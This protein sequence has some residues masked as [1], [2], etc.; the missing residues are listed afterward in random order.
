VVGL[1]GYATAQNLRLGVLHS[2]LSRDGPGLLLRDIRRGADDARAAAALIAAVQPDIL[3]LLR[4]DHDHELR[5]L[6]AFAAL[7][8]EA[9]HSFADRFSAL[10]NSG[11][12][13][14]IDL[15]GDGRIGTPDDAQGFG[16]FSGARGMALLSRYP[17]DRDGVRDFSTFAWRD[18]PDA[19][20]PEADGA[21]IPAP[22][23][24]ALQ[25]L[26]S[27]G[28]W[29]VPILLPEGQRL[30]LLAWHAGT[31]AFG[32]IPGRNARR[33]H[34]ENLFWVHFLDG[35]L[36]FAPPDAPFVLIGNSNLD[37]DAGGGDRGAI[38]RLL[39]HPAV[40]D[41]RPTGRRGTGPEGSATS[42]WDGGVGA[43]R[44][45]Y[46]LPAHGITVTGSGVEW[47]AEG[48][49]HGLVWMDIALP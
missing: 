46:I 24:F 19:R 33:N 35:N 40:Q 39:A 44:T 13:S 2:A 12:Q 29:Q 5:A 42:N 26:A 16:G 25:R 21:P 47:P 10:P 1:P 37:P 8:A 22:E 34:D 23:V 11:L 14:G 6:S 28:Y 9:G 18:L 43:L 4:F 31:P 32:R 45:S 41:P 15:D 27:T 7:L 48:G 17:I 20:V 3:L 36:P 30:V 38:Q 49:R